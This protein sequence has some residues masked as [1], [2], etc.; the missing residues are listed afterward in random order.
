MTTHTRTA[1][2]DLRLELDALDRFLVE[3][4]ARRQRLV[5]AIARHKGDPARVRDPDRVEE[6]LA[7]VLR[8]ARVAGL[9]PAIAEPLW[10]LLVERCAEHE[11]AWLGARAERLRDSCC[12]CEKDPAGPGF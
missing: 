7:N 2:A 12:G 1:L 11:S 5:E 10:R 6:V 4:L 8:A 9:S 3:T